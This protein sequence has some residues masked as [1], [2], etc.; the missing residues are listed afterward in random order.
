MGRDTIMFP[1][2]F[3]LLLICTLGVS[4]LALP[5]QASQTGETILVTG[6]TGRTGSLIY[7]EL[8]ASGFT[9][10]GLLRNV[11][12]AKEY[13]DCGACTADDGIFIGDVTKPETLSAPMKGVKRV[14]IAVG[15]VPLSDGKGGFYF[16]KGAYPKDI[17]WHGANNQVRAAA[18]A[19]VEHVLLVSSMG[20]TTPDSFLDK[21]GNGWAL[22]YKL[23]SEAFI[24][25]SGLQFTIVKP[26]GLTDTAPGKA[27][28]LVGHDDSITN[29][30]TMSVTR[31]D[32]ANVLVEAIKM[33]ANGANARFDLS[34]DGSKPA[35]GDFKALFKQAKE[36]G[37]QY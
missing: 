18:A 7:K 10:R 8:K 2:R 4:A 21:L 6:A 12:K 31:G 36:I 28:L 3:M 9:V 14:V 25:S 5:Q 17:D 30:T 13:L 23:N 22:F 11:T 29:Q 20:T 34:S 1:L 33:P 27:M 15:S 19:G 24:M 32:V 26:S 16:P 35:T 37:A